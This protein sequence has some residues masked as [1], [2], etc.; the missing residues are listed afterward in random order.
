VEDASHILGHRDYRDWRSEDATLLADIV[1]WQQELTNARG[2]IA[3]VEVALCEHEQALE[4]HAVALR[5]CQ[6]D[7]VAHEHALAEF[8]RGGAGK[9]I[10]EL[11]PTHHGEHEKHIQQLAVHERL[12]KRHYTTMSLMKLLVKAITNPE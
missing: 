5:A 9:E 11:A 12:K 10:L 2:E 3:K 4:T 6:Q 8:E 7:I 1:V